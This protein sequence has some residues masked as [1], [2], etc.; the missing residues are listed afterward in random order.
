MEMRSSKEA[1]CEGHP[2]PFIGNGSVCKKKGTIYLMAQIFEVF[3]YMFF[4]IKLKI[5]MLLLSLIERKELSM[6]DSVVHE[7]TIS[8]TTNILVFVIVLYSSLSDSF[9]NI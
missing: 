5:K 6:C 9:L 8:S 1:S 7:V 3:C 4:P 2:N